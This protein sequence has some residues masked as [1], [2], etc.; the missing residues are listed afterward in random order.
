MKKNWIYYVIAFLVVVIWSTTFISTKLLLN[1]LT[2]VEIMF[3][4][5]M[6]AY[7]LL[8]LMHP[9]FYKMKSLKEEALFIGAGIFGGTLY[10]LTE[11]Y[12]LQ[13]TLASNVGI[14]VAVAPILTAIFS[15][16]LIREEKFSKQAIMGSILSFLGVTLVVL[17]GRFVVQMNPLG[18]FL[19]IGAAI[20]WSIYS[21]LIKKIPHTY[22]G[23]YVT[24]KTFFYSILTMLPGV[25]VTGYRWDATLLQSPGI[26]A[27]LLFLGILASSICFVLWNRA[28]W[29][30]GPVTANNFIYFMPFITMIC[31]GL[32]L[33]E[34]ISFYAILGGIL[35]IGGVYIAEH[36]V[37][38]KESVKTITTD[39][40]V[41]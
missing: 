3:N 2:P 20:S 38:F 30:I 23:I 29:H 36:R 12:A 19:A 22:N 34:S 37:G 10:F 4:R 5:Y 7:V 35:I 40:G 41:L 21:I 16:F 26:M 8:W 1:T 33:K 31:S 18:D 39:K 6:I 25:I 27:H 11:N 15:H 13:Y 14:L 28:I 24:R 17:N 32:L 9:K